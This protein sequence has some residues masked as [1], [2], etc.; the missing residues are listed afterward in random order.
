M[1]IIKMMRMIVM[2]TVVMKIVQEEVT[3]PAMALAGRRSFCQSGDPINKIF[4][5]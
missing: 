2:S 1:I 4:F 3:I 5:F